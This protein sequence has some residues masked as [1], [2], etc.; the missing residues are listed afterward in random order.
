MSTIDNS[1][2]KDTW[3]SL[4]GIA[5]SYGLPLAEA[6]DLVSE[7]LIKALDH[8]DP[9]RGAFPVFCRTILRN[10]LKNYWRDRKIH[11]ELDPDSLEALSDTDPHTL[12]TYDQA[13]VAYVLERISGELTEEEREF[14]MMLGNV[15]QEIEARAVSEAAR[16]LGLPASKGWDVF[17]RIQ[18]KARKHR[19]AFLAEE[20]ISAATEQPSVLG[21]L[22]PE[23]TDRSLEEQEPSIA[24]IHFSRVC[25]HWSA[26]RPARRK[27]ALDLTMKSIALQFSRDEAFLRFESSLTC[28]QRDGLG[29]L[30]D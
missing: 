8:F 18:R 19:R 26:P 20:G 10:G 29:A 2:L 14:L 22:A 6:E 5:L 23:P 13:H 3:S 7:T 11:K 25:G 15:L 28:T 1:R 4:L 9:G 17:R 27:A 16:R 12:N 21:E 30:L 24:G